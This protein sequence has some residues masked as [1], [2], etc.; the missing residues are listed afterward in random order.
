MKL[1]EFLNEEVVDFKS[2]KQKELDKKSTETKSK[3]DA[4]KNIDHDVNKK[5]LDVKSRRANMKT[6]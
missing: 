6:V 5:K 2:K 3:V 4:L 1:K